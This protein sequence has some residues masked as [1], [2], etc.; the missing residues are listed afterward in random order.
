MLQSVASHFTMRCSS[1]SDFTIFLTITNHNV[2]RHTVNHCHSIRDSATPGTINVIP[3]QCLLLL[4]EALALITLMCPARSLNNWP[5]QDSY[6][7]TFCYSYTYCCTVTHTVV[8]LHLLLYS[9]TYCC[10]VTLNVTH[11]QLH[12]LLHLLLH[13]YTYCYS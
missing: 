8:Q 7:Y 3:K 11:L 5:D 9:Y 2:E 12:L 10:A 4:T 1:L 6:S 13:S